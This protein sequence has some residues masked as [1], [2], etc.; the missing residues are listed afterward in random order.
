MNKVLPHLDLSLF[1]E[2]LMSD[3]EP[4]PA[5]YAGSTPCTPTN[6]SKILFE[7]SAASQRER[8]APSPT[9]SS[10]V[11]AQLYASLRRSKEVEAEARSQLEQ[12]NSSRR[13]FL[14]WERDSQSPETSLREM[15]TSLNSTS[16]DRS[17]QPAERMENSA[18]ILLASRFGGSQEPFATPS[19]SQH[20]QMPLFVSPDDLISLSG[21]EA[22]Q[23][24]SAPP[25]TLRYEPKAVEVTAV[26]DHNHEDLDTLAKEMSRTLST[27]IQTSAVKQNGRRHISE[28]ESV[29]LHLQSML[30]ISA[31]SSHR[32]SLGL[33]APTNEKRGNDSFESDSTVNLINAQP[34]QE[35]SPPVSAT[36]LEE[37]FPRYA[38]LGPVAPRDPS[39]YSEI[40]LLRNSLEKERTR[41]KHLE[42]HIQNLQT[43]TLELHQQ[44]AIAI[45]ADKKKDAMIEQLD[46]TL[47]K[48]VEGWNK[49][50]AERNES[51]C[52][53]QEEK[54][55][56]EKVQAH[57]QEMLSKL[58]TKLAQVME[59]LSREQQAARD[60][61][62]EK[63]IL[64]GEKVLLARNLELEKERCLSLQSERDASVA[65]KTYEERQLETLRATLEEQQEAWAQR[66]R[67]LEERYCQ[68]KEENEFQIEREKLA[69]K[70]EAQHALDAQ[71]LL[72]SVQAEV[73]QLE[74]NLDVVRHER[75]SL[76][77]EISLAKV[78]YE[79]Q[80]LK[81]ESDLK[82]ALEQQVTEQLAEL[83]RENMQQMM[84][85]REQ[86]R[87]QLLELSTAQEKELASQ[88]SQFQAEMQERDEKQRRV[89]DEYELRLARNQEEIQDLLSSR[90]KLELQRA[91]MVGRLKTMMQ[92]HWNEAL[93]FLMSEGSSSGHQ[94]QRELSQPPLAASTDSVMPR[95]LDG[96]PPPP[97][98]SSLG[99]SEMERR[100]TPGASFQE[101]PQN[102]LPEH[103]GIT[104]SELRPHIDSWESH[105][106]FPWAVP[107]QPALQRSSQ[108]QDAQP[109]AASQQ[110]EHSSYVHSSEGKFYP[111]LSSD[112]SQLLNHS[113]V[114]Q[115]SFNPLEPLPDETALGFEQDN[116]AEHPF[117]DE[118]EKVMGSDPAVSEDSLL[119]NPSIEK[120][121][122]Q[123]LQQ[124]IQLLLDR[125]PGDPLNEKQEKPEQ[126]GS[127][128]FQDKLLDCWDQTRL[129]VSSQQIM[130]RIPPAVQKTKAPEIISRIISQGAYSPPKPNIG[131]QSGVV[132]PKALAEISRWLHCQQVRTDHTMPRM[133]ELLT[134]LQAMDHSKFQDKEERSYSQPSA[135][136]NLDPRLNEAV[137]KEP[138]SATR[139]PVSARPVSEKNQ[140][141]PKLSKKAAPSGQSS[142]KGSKS[143]IWR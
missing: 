91:E 29:R 70:K 107:L 99:L 90:R 80:K 4:F 34:L 127:L 66:E 78:R 55:A 95:T 42:R 75:D 44:L 68:L 92:S 123:D 31:A 125:T 105:A 62:K 36:G 119:Q 22:P 51:M 124:Y 38:S 18:R 126:G 35:A 79:S 76:Q 129:P 128:G 48:V 14:N 25:V 39:S 47:A 97:F 40:Q 58:E 106:A 12:C 6:V 85:L 81:L 140:L 3:V 143:G 96:N 16:R 71:Q 121:K 118:P 72:T 103:S 17:F 32:D 132:S 45:S 65:A 13:A 43:R 1:S 24:L 113:I 137:R 59:A 10:E 142:T 111:L 114:S 138:P 86:H 28:M 110:T 5:S 63:E 26:D 133:E 141:A 122:R 108:Q 20:P 82:V 104:V 8:T 69:F 74:G 64:E 15:N 50:E 52:R 60:R 83:H 130:S 9:H 115:Y 41:R 19:S 120:L 21:C 37:L 67:Q 89:M 11:T 61:E 135:R 93:R 30:Q 131:P 73:Q 98:T 101:G 46:K 94:L 77:L 87:K 112:L 139:R 134:Y 56:A 2:D 27:G 33:L 54:Q 23:E 136:R 7:G 84:T 57:R 53:L 49:H 88:L 100:A 116:P 117:T 102:S 109:S